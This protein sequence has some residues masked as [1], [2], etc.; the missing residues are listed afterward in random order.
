M[1]KHKFL[2]QNCDET[3]IST[4]QDPGKNPPKCVNRLGFV[5]SWERGKFISMLCT[6][7]AA[8]GF[9][10]PMCIF[11]RKRMSPHM[12]KDG[13]AGAIYK[14]SDN[15][16]IN[17]NFFFE[18]LQHFTAHTKPSLEQPILLILDYHAS[19]MSL[20]IFEYCKKITYIHTYAFTASAYITPH[21][22]A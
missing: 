6:M 14:C 8:G 21:A 11:P 10:A 5:T 15:G 19:H 4:G 16:W 7:S 18:G 3:G 20:Q 9:V 17:E 12:E 22:G 2:P 1:D 13:P